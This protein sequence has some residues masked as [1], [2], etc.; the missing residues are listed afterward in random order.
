MQAVG[1]K[2]YLLYVDLPLV[3]V[4]W[5]NLFGECLRFKKKG[6]DCDKK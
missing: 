4:S 2:D 5:S 3:R 6:R 1:G